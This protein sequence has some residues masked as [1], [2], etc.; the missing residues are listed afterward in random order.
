MASK[1][2]NKRFTGA[3]LGCALGVLAT[4][5]AAKADIFVN[6]AGIYDGSTISVNGQTEFATAVALTQT[7]S[8]SLFWVFCVD[9]SHNIQVN[10]GSQ[11]VFSPIQ[12]ASGTVTT[13]S[14]GAQSGTGSPLSPMPA[15]S[16]E[17]QYLASTGIAVI[18]AAGAQTPGSW[19][20]S[21]KAKLQ[22]IQ[23][24]IWAVEYNFTIGAS[25]AGK[26]NAGTENGAISTYISDAVT[27]VGQHPDAPLAGAI[28]A[29]NGA[30]QGQATGTGVPGLTTDVP[31][32]STWA[33]MLLGFCGVGFMAYR[34][35]SKPSFRLA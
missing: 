5:S 22:E 27:F 29:T 17:I 30:T 15:V 31:E 11:L 14:N 23:A 19:S 28:Y 35:K 26:I 1:L 8:S 2:T 21:V 34:R 3:L 18:N 25:G 32:P 13:N 24:A 9:L 4:G 33:M 16:Q 12:F 10:I 7:G 20:A 6:S